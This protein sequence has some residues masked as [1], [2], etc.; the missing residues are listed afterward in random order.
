MNND[1]TIKKILKT[2]PDGVR[3]VGRPKM[4]WEDGVEKDMR[5]LEVKNWKKVALYRNEW[6]K[7]LKKAKAH[8]E[9]SSQ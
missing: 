7:L 9:L 5:I 1:R 6:A 2:T 8:Q 4:R 3:R